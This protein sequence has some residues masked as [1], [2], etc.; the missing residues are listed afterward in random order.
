M[1]RALAWLA[2]V[3][4][5]PLPAQEGREQKALEQLRKMNVGLQLDEQ[6]PQRPLVAV[7]CSQVQFTDLGFK[8]IRLFPTIQR[9]NLSKTLITDAGM[10]SLRELTELQELTLEHTAITSAGLEAIKELPKLR[11]LNIDFCQKLDAEAFL[12]IRELKGLQILIARGIPASDKS[13]EYWA[14]SKPVHEP[15]AGSK[16]KPRKL[17]V[18]DPNPA[19]VTIYLSSSLKITDAGAEYLAN[20]PTLTEI[21]LSDTAITAKSIQRFARLPVLRSLNVSN[22]P[23][24]GDDALAPLPD[25]QALKACWFVN[26]PVTDAGLKH[27]ERATTLQSIAL[28]QSKATQAGIDALRAARPDLTVEF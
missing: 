25:Y 4:V 24:L 23:N 12:A 9:L 20:I 11:I 7:D 8:H 21:T 3:V 19:L 17:K 16:T 5:D 27:V 26:T 22:S 28:Q 15:P 10:K 18:S 13:L 2:L 6:S 14:A 1:K